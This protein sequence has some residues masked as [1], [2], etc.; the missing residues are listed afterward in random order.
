MGDGTGA[1]VVPGKGN[2]VYVRR[3]GRGLIEECLNNKAAARDGLPIIAGYS[4]ES[5]D[6]LQVLEV[7]WYSFSAPGAY[8]YTQHHHEAHELHNVVGGDDVVWVQSQQLM[9]L[10]VYG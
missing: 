9:P 4:H 6:V 3:L 2:Y 7:D 10:L 8:P 1:V 5:P